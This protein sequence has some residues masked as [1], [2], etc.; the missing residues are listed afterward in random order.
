[1]IRSLRDSFND[2]FTQ[3]RYAAFL[4]LLENR[5]STKIEFRVAETPVFLPASILEILSRAGADLLGSLM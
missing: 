2:R 5:C 4:K 1:V 3:E